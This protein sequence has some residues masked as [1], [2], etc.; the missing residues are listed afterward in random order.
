ME[1]GRNWGQRE[2]ST[3]NS[4]IEGVGGSLV[5]AEQTIVRKEVMGTGERV[6]CKN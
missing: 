5:K 1:A 2:K 6:T 3:C 4:R